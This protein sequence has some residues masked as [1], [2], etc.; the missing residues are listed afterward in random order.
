M[1][2]FIYL[3][4]AYDKFRKIVCFYLTMKRKNMN[5]DENKTKRTNTVNNQ[6][7]FLLM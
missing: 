4:F 6:V 5:D 1:N 7:I 3:K 2:L